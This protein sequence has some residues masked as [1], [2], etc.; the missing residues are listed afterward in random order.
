MAPQL[1]KVVGAVFSFFNTLRS[2]A[3]HF[4]VVVVVVDI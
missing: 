4:I 1:S 3:G 2:Y